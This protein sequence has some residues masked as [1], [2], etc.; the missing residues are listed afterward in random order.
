[1]KDLK[2]MLTYNRAAHTPSEQAFVDRFIDRVP[3]M[4]QDAYG[5]RYLRLGERPTTLFS[6][7]TDSVHLADGRQCVQ[8]DRQARVFYKDDHQPL[9][10][11]NATG[12]WLLL[13]LI[14]AGIPGLY[15]FHREEEIGCR[16]SDWIA[17]HA[18]PR[19]AGIQRAI[20]FDWHGQTDII[21]Q[22]EGDRCCSEAFATALAAQL[23]LGFTPGT[24]GSFSDI[25]CYLGLIPEC[26]NISV[27]FS[28]AHTGAEYQDY[29]FL[30]DLLPAL[31]AVDWDGL[32]VARAC[33]P[34][35]WYAKL[36]FRFLFDGLD[37]GD[38]IDFAAMAAMVAAGR[39]PP[40]RELARIMGPTIC[41][42]VEG[43]RADARDW[44]GRLIMR[45]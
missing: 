10:A 16:G 42:G 11:D 15:L 40:P 36:N 4:R 20:A 18:A 13:K 1:M 33:V 2:E 31:L 3:G 26:T 38:G 29:A 34:V 37:L 35:P 12:C 43:L 17:H 24:D 28:N 22:F 30:L 8:E 9:G 45:D 19:L 41:A 44:R 32:P 7:H 14:A 27:G 21:T 25:G 6:A 23:G 39:Y 5:N